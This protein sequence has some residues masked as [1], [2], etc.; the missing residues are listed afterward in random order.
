MSSL[1]KRREIVQAFH[2]L[3]KTLGC[4]DVGSNM[5]L[6]Y[7]E[8]SSYVLE[9]SCLVYLMHQLPYCMRCD[10][11]VKASTPFCPECLSHGFLTPVWRSCKTKSCFNEEDVKKVLFWFYFSRDKKP[12]LEKAKGMV[13]R[14]TA[15]V[16]YYSRIY[17]IPVVAVI[18]ELLNSKVW[19]SIPFTSTSGMLQAVKEHSLGNIHA[20]TSQNAVSVFERWG[21]SV[22][23][24]SITNIT[25]AQSPTSTR[26]LLEMLNES[27]SLREAE[28]KGLS[29]AENTP[30]GQDHNPMLTPDGVLS[31]V[32]LS[33]EKQNAL[34][35]SYTHSFIS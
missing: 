23:S 5:Q 24:H 26:Q 8:M 3:Y 6:S 33:E 17:Y 30:P 25:K 35:D 27:F 18:A 9:H 14:H 7:D 13:C 31:F 10:R 12:A 21:C 2:D 20:L 19:S 15:K 22:V 4:K 29:S 28:L 1:E 16:C 34:R 32:P 11:F